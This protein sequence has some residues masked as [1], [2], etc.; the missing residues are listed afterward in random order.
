MGKHKKLLREGL[1]KILS[2][3]GKPPPGG[4][5]VPRAWVEAN[6]LRPCCGTPHGTGHRGTC[7]FSLMRGGTLADV[8]DSPER[9]SN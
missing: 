9:P 5:I 7:D 1:R 4:S 8:G 3:Y 2:E 6:L